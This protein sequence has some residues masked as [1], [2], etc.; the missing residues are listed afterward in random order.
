[1][2]RTY[3]FHLI[4]RSLSGIAVTLSIILVVFLAEQL[5]TLVETLVEQRISFLEL[6]WALTL[7]APEIVI[8]AMPL[9]VLIGIYRALL[10]AR[11]SG[12]TVALAGAGVGPWGLFGSL[13]AMGVVLVAVV[14]AVAGFVDPL[15][16]TTRDRMFLE[17]GHALVV[18]AVRDGLEPDQFRSLNGY[19][20]VALPSPN[21]MDH[22][23]L[24]FFP[25]SGDSERIVSTN[26]YDLVDAGDGTHFKLKLQDVVVADVGLTA[27][28]GAA[29]P[30]VDDGAAGGS[31]FR[32]GTL[33]Q[34]VDLDDALRDPTLEDDPQYRMLPALLTGAGSATDEGGLRIR[35]LEILGRS[36]LTVAAVFLAAIAVSYASGLLRFF[37]LPAAGASLVAIDIALVRAVRGLDALPLWASLAAALAIGLAVVT[38][39]AVAAALRYPGVVAPRGGRA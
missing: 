33:T 1:M 9:A 29:A 21:A 31:S 4:G 38:A 2:G 3:A 27:P 5:T 6:P 34:S 36:G 35:A 22:R 23:L 13:V 17:A 28:R 10:D 7:T 8:T 24:L 12:E 19:T 14:I 15:A 18:A 26:S 39:L 20:F 16:R 11:D 37:V 25:R 32:L 30:T